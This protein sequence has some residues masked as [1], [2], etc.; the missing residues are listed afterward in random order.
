MVFCEGKRGPFFVGLRSFLMRDS[1]AFEQFTM[2]VLIFLLPDDLDY[3]FQF[4]CPSDVGWRVGVT[5]GCATAVSFTPDSPQFSRRVCTDCGDALFFF[6]KLKEGVSVYSL[7]R[8]RIHCSFPQS[9]RRHRIIELLRNYR[10]YY[11]VAFWAIH[12]VVLRLW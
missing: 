1:F 8:Y 3:F 4:I 7:T 2:R 5:R 9:R 6:K 10:I 12:F 11:Q